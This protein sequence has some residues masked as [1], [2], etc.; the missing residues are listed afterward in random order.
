[1]NR[2]ELYR[3]SNSC[4]W[5]KYVLPNHIQYLDKEGEIKFEDLDPENTFIVFP[6]EDS[7]NLH[8]F[9]FNLDKLIEL[10][11]VIEN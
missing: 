2:F 10:G 4:V 7:E 11:H 1:M 9:D 5:C 6:G 8:S 3:S